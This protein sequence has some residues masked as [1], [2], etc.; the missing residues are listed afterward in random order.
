MIQDLEQI[1]FR[2]GMLENGMKPDVLP[3]KIWRGGKISEEIRKAI[4]EEDILNL[5]GVY[6]D[7]NA[8]EVVSDEFDAAVVAS[9]EALE[10]S[11]LC[12]LHLKKIG[13]P[14]IYA[15]AANEDHAQI[16]TSV[17]ATHVVFPERE[18]ATRT[19][20]QIINPAFMDFIPL[21]KDFNLIEIPAPD[22]FIGKS[23][24]ELNIRKTL[25]VFV[26]AIKEEGEYVFLPEADLVIQRKHQLVIIGRDKNLQQFQEK[27]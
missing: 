8:S 1:E 21:V 14:V 24:L 17:G 5:G 13:V 10:V 15:K 3:V 4:N 12:T 20:A 26:L 25:Q 11:I 23:L 2:K 7:E 6:G 16:L 19:S 18:S 22:A 27:M 9:S